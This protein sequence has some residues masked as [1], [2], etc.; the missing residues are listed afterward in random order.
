MGIVKWARAKSPWV[1]HIN[2]G[3]CNGCDIEVAAALAPVFDLERF[4]I[5]KKGSPRHADILLVTGVVTR[6]WKER[7]LRLYEQMSKP[8]MVI[9][10]GACAI[11][12]GAFRESYNISDV[13]DTILPVDFYIIGCPPKPEAII[14]GILG[15]SSKQG[16]KVEK[17]HGEI[18]NDR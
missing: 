1:M 12:G 15:L 10:V 17:R 16:P 4:G 5:Q 3:S 9:A 13:L 11:T 14:Y 6:P 8:V 7:I 2:A 18:E